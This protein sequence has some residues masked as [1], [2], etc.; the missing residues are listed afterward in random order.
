MNTRKKAKEYIHFTYERFFKKRRYTTRR[1]KQNKRRRLGP[2]IIKNNPS[3][4][5]H[6]QAIIIEFKTHLLMS[7]KDLVYKEL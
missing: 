5:E 4:V 7:E 6:I 2:L 3:T 1:K